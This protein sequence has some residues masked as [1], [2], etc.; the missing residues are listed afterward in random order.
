LFPDMDKSDKE[1]ILGIDFGSRRIGLSIS[2]PLRIIAK[3]YETLKNDVTL[4]NR[5]KAIIARESIRFCVIGMPVT[6]K[7]E[8]ASKAKEVESFVE[9]LRK[10]TGLEVVLW[11]ERFTTSIAQQTLREMNVKKKGRDSK[12]GSLDSMAAAIILQSFLDSGKKS[13]IC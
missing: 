6:L 5:L 9:E 10:E 1:R 3:P 12:N 4:W 13:L 11:D 8:K 2:D 7:G